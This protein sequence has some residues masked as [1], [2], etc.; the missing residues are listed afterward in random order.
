MKR[1][2]KRKEKKRNQFYETMKQ[3]IFKVIN[4]FS[5]VKIIVYNNNS[6]NKKE[7]KFN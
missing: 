2:K 7:L 5:T 4:Y 6:N 1:I 3:I